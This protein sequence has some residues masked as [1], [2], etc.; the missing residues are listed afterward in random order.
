[1]FPAEIS[2]LYV[3]ICIYLFIYFVMSE[4]AL[5]KLVKYV[6]SLG[7]EMIG[8]AFLRFMGLGSKRRQT[9]KTF[10][11]WL[12][13]CI[14]YLD[15]IESLSWIWRSALKPRHRQLQCRPTLDRAFDTFQL[16]ILRYICHCHVLYVYW[17]LDNVPVFVTV[18]FYVCIDYSHFG[19]Y[20]VT[21]SW[22]FH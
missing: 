15:S 8:W 4:F 5:V 21:K 3:N 12:M 13:W 22:C 18:L 11:V 20:C 7:L 10:L 19:G 17:S 6:E 16:L 9:E 14:L 2:H 1:M